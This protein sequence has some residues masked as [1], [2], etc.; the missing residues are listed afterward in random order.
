MRRAPGMASTATKAAATHQGQLLAQLSDHIDLPVNGHTVPSTAHNSSS[1]RSYTSINIWHEQSTQQIMIC[2]YK[3]AKLEA[4][5]TMLF[6]GADISV[7]E[8]VLPYCLNSS[9]CTKEQLLKKK[10]KEV[11]ISSTKIQLKSGI[12]ALPG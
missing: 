8:S 2:K 9:S 11:K 6:T 3:E 5:C 7:S 1:V 12:F 4:I 10:K